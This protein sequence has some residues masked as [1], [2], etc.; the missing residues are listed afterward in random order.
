MPSVDHI[1]SMKM[2]DKGLEVIKR[3]EG[4]RLGA[5]KCSSNLWTIGYGHTQGVKAGQRISQAQADAFLRS[6]VKTAEDAVRGHELKLTQN[7]FDAFVSLT[8]NIG[9]GAFGGSTALR[10]AKVN[11]NDPKIGDAIK[12][13]NKGGGKVL[14]GLVNRR[15]VEVAH[16]FA[17]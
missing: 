14:Q 3:F 5:Y 13:W 11:P 16:Y 1:T 17:K 4:L 2:S 10:L 7:Q 9:I 8:Y 6:D 15:A 12:M